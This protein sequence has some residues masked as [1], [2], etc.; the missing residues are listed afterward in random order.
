MRMRLPVVVCVVLA[1]ACGQPPDKLGVM[2]DRV[3]YQ[4]TNAGPAPPDVASAQF[5]SPSSLLRVVR[6]DLFGDERPE[7]MIE[8]DDHHGVDIQDASGSIVGRVTTTEY[9]TDFG[10]ILSGGERLIVIYTYPN[11]TRGGTFVVTT[12]QQRELARWSENVPP[13]HFATG[14]WQQT[15]AVFYLVQ[16]RLTIRSTGGAILASLDAPSGHDFGQL[17]V[18]PTAG[19]RLVVVASG[20]GYTPYHMVCVYD[21]SGEL[22]FQEIENEHAFGSETSVERG[23]FIVTTRSTR[24][25]YQPGS[26]HA[27]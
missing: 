5:V 9:L 19:D 22:L 2:I 3:S 16:D 13:S 27:P 17:F 25:K 11:A 14:L 7:T 1:A 8:R 21:A 26:A 6:A 18:G 12:P 10:A 20:S 4:R 15:P 24:W 23:S